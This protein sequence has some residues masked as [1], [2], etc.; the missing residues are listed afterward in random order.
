MELTGFNAA[1]VEPNA[2]FEPLPANWYKV[3]ITESEEKPTRAQT[4]SYLQ[5][6]LEVI[7]GPHAGRKVFDRLNLNNPNDTAVQIAQQTL[8]AICHAVGVMTPRQSSDLHD[9]PMMAKIAVKPPANGYEAS[10]EVK[11]YEA[12][13]KK[14]VTAPGDGGDGGASLPPWKRKAG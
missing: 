5:L 8:S 11:G 10:N 14:A 7:D 2:A 6:T 9:K 1:E 12:A 13:S 3:V 4:G